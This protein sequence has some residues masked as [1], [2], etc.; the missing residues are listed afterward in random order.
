MAA[1]R[2]AHS[3]SCC[4]ITFDDNCVSV[5]FAQTA[6]NIERR[7]GKKN[8]YGK[9][10]GAQPRAQKA[11]QNARRRSPQHRNNVRVLFVH[12]GVSYASIM[13][14][15]NAT[16]RIARKGCLLNFN[17][18]PRQT[19][20]LPRDSPHQSSPGAVGNHHTAFQSPRWCVWCR[21][22]QIQNRSA[23]MS[24]LLGNRSLQWIH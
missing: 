1:Q 12:N 11:L 20:T 16:V 7:R 9:G 2:E 17:A 8:P 22:P 4:V 13:M 10:C 14:G 18:G 3:V 15:K 5:F 24:T 21:P 19:S 6:R 23:Q